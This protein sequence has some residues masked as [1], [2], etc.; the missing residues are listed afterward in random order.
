MKRF[1]LLMAALVISASGAS[2]KDKMEKVDIAL[3]GIDT[4]TLVVRA[5]GQNYKTAITKEYRFLVR[6]FASAK[7]LYRIVD[8]WFYTGRPLDKGYQMPL[9][10]RDYGSGEEKSVK[11]PVDF[12]VAT[13]RILWDGPGPVEACNANL[14]KLKQ[15]GFTTQQVL[16]KTHALKVKALVGFG[17]A[18][19]RKGKT[20]SPVGM[21]G[22]ATYEHKTLSYP[23]AVECRP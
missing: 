20:A 7:G 13:A 2:A 21:G 10:P 16:A 18:A 1:A 4:Q 23:V 8:A 11:R 17:A 3:D 19:D 12:K 9:V 5:S 14:I 22:G 15:A 6:G